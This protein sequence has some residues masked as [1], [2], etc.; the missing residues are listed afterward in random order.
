MA[1]PPANGKSGA[2]ANGSPT[3]TA[4]KAGGASA[5]P[6]YSRGNSNGKAGKSAVDASPSRTVFLAVTETDDAVSDAQLLR[7]VIGVIL[8]FP[9]KDRVNL[10]IR[11]GGRRVVMELP[12]VSTGYCQDLKQRLETLLGPDSVALE[13]KNGS[14]EEDA[15][16]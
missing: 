6:T 12:V 11:T 10:T 3:R 4:A 16:V 7:E 13:D 5:G 14:N 9:G 1:P 2:P 15:P 8:D